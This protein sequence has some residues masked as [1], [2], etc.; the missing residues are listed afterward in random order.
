LR[1]VFAKLAAL[2]ASATLLP[3]QSVGPRDLDRL[4]SSAPTVTLAYGSGTLQFGDLRLPPG[5]GPFPVVEVIHG[6]CWTAG[7]AMR[8]NT[9]ALASELTKHGYATWNIEY[10]Q[11]GDVGGGWPGTFLDWATATDYLRVMAK[12][13]PIDL[14]H[15]YTV[16]HSAGGHAALWIASRAK[17]P[18]NSEIRGGSNPL[19]VRGAVDIDGPG[20]MRPIVAYTAQYCGKPIIAEFFGGTPAQQTVRYSQGSPM[21]Q[22]PL[23]VPQLLIQSSFLEKQPAEA[24]ANAGKAAGDAVRVFQVKDAGHFDLIAPGSPAWQQVL[25]ELLKALQ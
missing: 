11:V 25:P 1:R 5:K 15:V 20:D 22:L 23:H 24:Y 12:T 13:Q 6:G 4:P 21:D 9:A 18:A 8:Q 16:G 10:R 2:L 14:T 19:P 17:L 7:Y 3:A